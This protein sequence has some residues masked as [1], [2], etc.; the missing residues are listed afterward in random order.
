MEI[1]QFGSGTRN[2]FSNVNKILDTATGIKL[3]SICKQAFSDYEFFFKKEYKEKTFPYKNNFFTREFLN[4]FTDF[5]DSTICMP[6]IHFVQMHNFFTFQFEHSIDSKREFISI[7]HSI[8]LLS[9]VMSA[10]R[11]KDEGDFLYWFKKSIL[12]TLST[13]CNAKLE[14][15][16]LSPYRENSSTPMLSI[17][18]IS[19]FQL[20]K[21]LKKCNTEF[22]TNI[23]LSLKNT[24]NNFVLSGINSDLSVLYKYLMENHDSYNYVLSFLDC[25][26][27][28]HSSLLTP[29]IKKIV[30]ENSFVGFNIKKTN[31][32]LPVIFTNN[33]ENIQNCESP[34][35]NILRSLLTDCVDWQKVILSITQKNFCKINDFGP[36]LPVNMFTKKI[37]NDLKWNFKLL[38]YPKL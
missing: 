9:A 24:N 30:Y 12:F 36:S 1:L 23:E 22:C 14:I 10:L 16:K 26:I 15:E 27:P 32:K 31:F 13:L 7:G 6:Y 38:T 28:F 21:I 20:K 33:G 37:L 4:N 29:A 35:E 25:N 8:G 17:S 34:Y 11:Y 18:N 19:F 5:S 3:F 2:I